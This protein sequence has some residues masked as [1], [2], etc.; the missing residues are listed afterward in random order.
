M[1]AEE[2]KPTDVQVFNPETGDWEIRKVGSWTPGYSDRRKPVKITKSGFSE[3]G[4]LIEE[5]VEEPEESEGLGELEQ[6]VGMDEQDELIEQLVADRLEEMLKNGEVDPRPSRKTSIEGAL[7]NDPGVKVRFTVPGFG[8]ISSLYRDWGESE[9]GLII[10]LAS[11]MDEENEIVPATYQE[12]KAVI[13]LQTIET[14]TEATGYSEPVLYLG[15][16][17]LEEKNLRIH[18]YLKKSKLDALAGGAE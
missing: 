6:A 1:S 17:E 10:V 15:A 16:V 4:E 12:S 13:S 3:S 14:N 9:D 2:K 5:E 11:N 8:Q 7:K 18:I